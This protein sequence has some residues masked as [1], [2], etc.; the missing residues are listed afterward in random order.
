MC[1]KYFSLERYVREH[2]SHLKLNFL[3]GLL[4]LEI[5]DEAIG[6]LSLSIIVGSLSV[7][8]GNSI[9]GNSGAVVV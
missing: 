3:M 9:M 5:P 7:T 1:F 6:L 8:V 2:S 4:L